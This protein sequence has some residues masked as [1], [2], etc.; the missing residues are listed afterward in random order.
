M[1]NSKKPSPARPWV[2]QQLTEAKAKPAVART[3]CLLLDVWESSNTKLSEKDE[4]STLEF[5][6]KLAMHQTIIDE[7]EENVV[8]AEV[9]PGSV[10]VGDIVRVKSDAFKGAIG[11]MHNGRIGKIIVSR[12]G[13]II[14]KITDSRLPVLDEPRYSPFHLER[15]VVK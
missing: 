14:V 3:V 9:S 13:D 15:K 6:S 11:E 8:W 4:E 5:F 10:K 1:S 12:Q 2:L 7:K